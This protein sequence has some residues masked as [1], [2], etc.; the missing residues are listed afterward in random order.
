MTFTLR[1]DEII[2]VATHGLAGSV[3]VIEGEMSLNDTAVLVRRH[4]TAP[5]YDRAGS[6]FWRARFY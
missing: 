6:C 1:L 5:V 2:A 4:A 3:T